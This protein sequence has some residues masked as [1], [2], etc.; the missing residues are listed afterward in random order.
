MRFRM[1]LLGVVGVVGC[2]VESQ[3]G[4]INLFGLQTATHAA[5]RHSSFSMRD[6]FAAL[7]HLSSDARSRNWYQAVQ[8]SIDTTPDS[9]ILDDHSRVG[10][11]PVVPANW[12]LGNAR[13]AIGSLSRGHNAQPKWKKDQCK[14]GPCP[15]R[16]PEPTTA[17]L[18][19]IG[20]GLVAVSPRL[21][22]RH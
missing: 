9:L 16:V 1:V 18:L 17:L 12:W 15:T 22:R 2:A 21:R 6:E 3:A 7:G 10:P 14:G 11:L 8:L 5:S 13:P 4:P 19:A 20:S